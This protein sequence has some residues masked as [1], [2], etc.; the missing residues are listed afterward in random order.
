M[1]GKEL[2]S[3]RTDEEETFGSLYTLPT[4]WQ[5]TQVAREQ[6]S[7]L[8]TSSDLFATG[9]RSSYRPG[10]SAA[11][12]IKELTNCG[13]PGPA[14]WSIGMMECLDRVA[15]AAQS[16]RWVRAANSIRSLCR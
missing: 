8:A 14:L 11:G 9:C 1:G 2:V 10:E 12:P 5:P 13:A 16:A 3:N 7:L 4:K 15:T 6:T